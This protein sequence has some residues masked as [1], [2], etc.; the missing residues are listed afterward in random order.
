MFFLSFLF[1]LKNVSVAH[2]IL[3]IV[4]SLKHKDQHNL[5]KF[6]FLGK[7]AALN[8]WTWVIFI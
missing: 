2:G 8:L 6:D 1:I 5:K 7:K 4:T 3:S